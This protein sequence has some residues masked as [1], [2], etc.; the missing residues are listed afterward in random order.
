[1]SNNIMHHDQQV[2]EIKGPI[3]KPIKIANSVSKSKIKKA[4][5]N[6]KGQFNKFADWIMSYVP[7][8]AK[9]PCNKRVEGL[10][11]KVNAIYKSLKKTSSVKKL[12]SVMF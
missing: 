3:V 9:K 1:M 4:V 5:D 12:E 11:N 6:K 8:E 2:P 7:Q 10:K